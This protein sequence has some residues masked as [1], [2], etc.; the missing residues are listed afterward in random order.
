[1]GL[2]A[3]VLGLLAQLRELIVALEAQLETLEAELVARVKDQ[4]RP[5][6]LGEITLVTL[7]GEMC[8]WGRFNNRKQIGSY[9]GCCPGE[10]SS[11][12]NG[13]WAALIAWVTGG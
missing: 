2:D 3:W 1:V 12:G 9:T 8:D 6:G 13:G 10:H 7:E 11:G 5:K 4:E